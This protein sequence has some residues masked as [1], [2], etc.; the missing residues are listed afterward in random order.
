MALSRVPNRYIARGDLIALLDRLW[1]GQYHVE[2]REVRPYT[3]ANID[4]SVGA[5]RY[6]GDHRYSARTQQ[7]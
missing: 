6:L 2:V 7:R 5:R 3:A 1:P 4:A